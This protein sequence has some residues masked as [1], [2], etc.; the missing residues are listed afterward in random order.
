MWEIVHVE[1][2]DVVAEADDR[3]EAQW[4]LRSARTRWPG[5]TFILR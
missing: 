2:G 4:L 3:D 5:S 1:T